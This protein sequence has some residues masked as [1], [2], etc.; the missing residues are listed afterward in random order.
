MG[1]KAVDLAIRSMNDENFEPQ[2]LAIKP[3]LI[4]RQSC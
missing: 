2:T 1:E 4:K 3:E